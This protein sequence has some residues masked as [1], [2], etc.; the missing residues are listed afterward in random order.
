MVVCRRGRQ[1]PQC[2]T[3]AASAPTRLR[4]QLLPLL[5]VCGAPVERQARERR[6]ALQGIARSLGGPSQKRDGD[7]KGDTSNGTVVAST[8]PHQ[9]GPANAPGREDRQGHKKPVAARGP[10]PGLLWAR[11]RTRML[12]GQQGVRCGRPCGNLPV[13]A[14]SAHVGLTHRWPASSRLATC[15]TGCRTGRLP[16][17]PRPEGCPAISR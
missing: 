17:Y 6:P 7:E 1:S 11:G 12:T 10:A 16:V 13:A 9:L 14:A 8:L 2:H 15:A 5:V 4:S 3:V